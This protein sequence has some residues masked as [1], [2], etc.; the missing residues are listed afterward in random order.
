MVKYVCTIV[1]P[2]LSG[3]VSRQTHP[4]ISVMEGSSESFASKQMTQSSAVAEADAGSAS[5]DSSTSAAFEGKLDARSKAVAFVIHPLLIHCKRFQ[6]VG[7]R[8]GKSAQSK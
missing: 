2:P 1:R 7:H 5:T 4:S 6:V 3:L 8:V